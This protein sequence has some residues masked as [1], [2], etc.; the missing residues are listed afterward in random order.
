MKFLAGLLSIFAAIRT[1]RAQ[2]GVEVP[3]VGSVVKLIPLAYIQL[4]GRIQNAS[5]NSQI[6]LIGSVRKGNLMSYFFSVGSNFFVGVQY[7]PAGS[8]AESVKAF[9][10]GPNLQNV[11]AGLGHIQ[12]ELSQVSTS[13]RNYSTDFLQNNP[14]SIISGSSYFSTPIATTQ[15]LLMVTKTPTLSLPQP[16][17]M[18]TPTLSL[19]Q[20]S[21]MA[22]Q[23]PSLP[24]QRSEAPTAET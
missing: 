5:P 22:T 16:P 6:A 10:M 15:P 13:S 4:S 3:G 7:D 1:A 20:P 14:I 9:S 18:A 19:P 23:P 11:L 21:L 2:N 12:S 8:N 24:P 17:L